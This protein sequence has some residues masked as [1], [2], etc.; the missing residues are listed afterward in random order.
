MIENR[1][2][3]RGRGDG[4]YHLGWIHKTGDNTERKRAK[5]L[6]AAARKIDE[7]RAEQVRGYFGEHLSVGI[8][9]RVRRERDGL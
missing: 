9:V 5:R 3:L 4:R 1:L 6:G 2:A 7:L 8:F